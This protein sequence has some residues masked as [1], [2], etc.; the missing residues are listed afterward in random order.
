MAKGKTKSTKQKGG[1]K[2]GAPEGPLKDAREDVAEPGDG[3]EA[4]HGH[5]AEQATSSD[6]ADTID[7][8]EPTLH[9][10]ALEADSES[11]EIDV[12]AEE[13]GAADSATASGEPM[14]THAETDSG[15][16]KT[17]RSSKA[18]SSKT[19][20]KSATKGSKRTH[21]ALQDGASQDGV[22][23]DG[24]EPSA[25]TAPESLGETSDAAAPEAPEGH[26][27]AAPLDDETALSAEDASAPADAPETSMAEAE[28]N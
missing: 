21:R 26:E 8:V 9:E 19:R 7:T 10:D 27:V 6:T 2:K 15:K 14:D 17:K 23:K 1:P 22:L 28:T 18:A 11:P 20:T 13:A 3:A 12:P 5:G 4:L 25:E 16:K 24:A